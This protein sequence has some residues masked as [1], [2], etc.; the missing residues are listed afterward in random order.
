[1]QPVL[2]TREQRLITYLIDLIPAI[3]A[4]VLVGWIPI[5]GA[6]LAG[7][8]LGSYWLFRDVTGGSL[9]KLALGL[10]V[11]NRDGS[12]ANVGSRVLRNLT[13]AAGPGLLIIPLLGYAL[14][15]LMAALLIITES[16]MLLTQGERLGDKLAGTAVFR[17]DSLPGQVSTTTAG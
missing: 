4:S 13:I 10:R 7:F 14:A 12:E 15:P 6:I 11:R 3:T 8:I 1:M 5:L 9:G 16:I 2:A 17:A